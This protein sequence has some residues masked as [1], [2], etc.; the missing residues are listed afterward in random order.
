MYMKLKK[1]MCAFVA[2]LVVLSG[3]S[4]S[5]TTSE[6]G[7]V[8]TITTAQVVEKM[9]NKEEFVVVFTQT[10]CDHCKIFMNMLDEY[11]PKHNITMYDMILDH[12]GNREQALKELGTL[13]PDFTGTPDIYYVKDGKIE[14]RFWD[15]YQ[16]EGLTETTFNAWVNKHELLK[17]NESEK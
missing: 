4:G 11:L 3:C 5:G 8:E 6:P 13:F 9:N 17:I 16:S 10:T 14:S 7:K 2:L 12:E 1:Y 15:E